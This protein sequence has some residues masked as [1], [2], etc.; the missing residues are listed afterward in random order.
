MGKGAVP[1]GWSYHGPWTPCLGQFSLKGPEQVP[2]TRLEEKHSFY[3]ELGVS[4]LD[5]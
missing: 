5:T 2:N 1:V 3:V 4:F